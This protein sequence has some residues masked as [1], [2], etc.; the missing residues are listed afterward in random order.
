MAKLGRPRTRFVSSGYTRA[1]DALSYAS[2]RAGIGYPDDGGKAWNAYR[3]AQFQSYFRTHKDFGKRDDLDYTILMRTTPVTPWHIELFLKYLERE[4]VTVGVHKKEAKR[5]IVTPVWRFQYMGLRSRPSLKHQPWEFF[6]EPN[7]DL[8][9]EDTNVVE[10]WQKFGEVE[11]RTNVPWNL[12]GSVDTREFKYFINAWERKMTTPI[13][14]DAYYKLKNPKITAESSS[15]A[16][17]GYLL[18]KGDPVRGIAPRNWLHG[19]IEENMYT[20]NK[21]LSYKIEQLFYKVLDV[22]TLGPWIVIGGRGYLYSR[23]DL[24]YA[25]QNR[26]SYSYKAP[27]YRPTNPRPNL[28]YGF[29]MNEPMTVGR[30]YPAD[31]KYRFSA[32]NLSD[33]AADMIRTLHR[34]RALV[35]PVFAWVTNSVKSALV[36]KAPENKPFTKDYKREGG[37]DTRGNKLMD[38]GHFSGD[39]LPYLY[40]GGWGDTI[41]KGI[42]TGQLLASITY[43]WD[44]S[45]N[46]EKSRGGSNA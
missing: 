14:H 34:F 15:N 28:W 9:E 4:S 7:W 45:R 24:N 22:G 18:E 16:A 2:S 37:R 19:T 26:Y 1:A 30:D 21:A 43:K 6:D 20:I 3:Y 17:L 40:G 25:V 5:R 39:D 11:G 38:F 23:P 27:D 31:G 12:E 35:N 46:I 13:T 36:S 8:G 44:D 42:F 41:K 10:E 33:Q 29:R 32:G